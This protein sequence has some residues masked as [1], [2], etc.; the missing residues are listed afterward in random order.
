MGKLEKFW[1]IRGEKYRASKWPYFFQR[2]MQ[3]TYSLLPNHFNIHEIQISH[4]EVG[5]KQVTPNVGTHNIHTSQ[6]A[7]IRPPAN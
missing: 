6:K 2:S 1:P 7:K 3:Q 4:P 5:K